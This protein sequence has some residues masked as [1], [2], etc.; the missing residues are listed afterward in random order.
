MAKGV[1]ADK[2]TCYCVFAR[3]MVSFLETDEEEQLSIE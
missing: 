2:N 3:K 1:G